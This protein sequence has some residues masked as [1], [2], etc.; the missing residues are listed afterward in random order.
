MVIGAR[1]WA[2]AVVEGPEA[3]VEARLPHPAVQIPIDATTAT[4]RIENNVRERALSMGLLPSP[5]AKQWTASV[6]GD[7]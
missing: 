2:D 5:A 1:T 6:V 4:G 7:C 3:G